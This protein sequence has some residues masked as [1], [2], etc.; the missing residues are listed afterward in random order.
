MTR[1][2]TT[3]DG[4]DPTVAFGATGDPAPGPPLAPGAT[5]DAGWVINWSGHIY[6]TVSGNP[7]LPAGFVAGQGPGVRLIDLREPQ[8][9]VG[10]TGYIP[11]S[12]WIPAERLDSL[13]G[14]LD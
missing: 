6:R 9:F 10:E 12:D 3:A 7:M 2:M 5:P 11:G 13:A 8:A 1:T 14:R 4:W